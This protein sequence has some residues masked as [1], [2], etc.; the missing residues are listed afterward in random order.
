VD[1]L[2]RA[3]KAALNVTA[4]S[5]ERQL[6]Q[7][8]SPL[9]GNVGTQEGAHFQNATVRVWIDT[10]TDRIRKVQREIHVALFQIRR[11]DQHHTTGVRGIRIRVGD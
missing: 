11:P 9:P 6:Q 4:Q 10:E 1:A 2:E 7:S 5:T 8:R 3:Q